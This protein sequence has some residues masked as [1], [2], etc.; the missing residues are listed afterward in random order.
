MSKKIINILS[1]DGGGSKGL[2]PAYLIKALSKE[3]DNN[4]LYNQFDLIA[5]TSTGALITLLLTSPQIA[6]NSNVDRTSLI[7]DLYKNESKKIF[8]NKFMLFK[9]LKQL[10]KPKFSNKYLSKLLEEYLGTT[11]IKNA[12]TNIIIP[13]FDMNTMQPY[14]F[15]NRP[16]YNGSCS[17]LNFYMK[18]VALASTAAPTYLPPHYTKTVDDFYSFNF[19]DGGLFANNPSM[20]AYIEAIKLFPNAKEFNIISLGT[21]YVRRSYTYK[22]VK[23][24]GALGWMNP[25]NNVPII[26]SYMYSQ[27]GSTSHKVSQISN[28]N[29][30]RFNPNISCAGLG[31]DSTTDEAIKT[32]QEISY[33]YISEYYFRI[34]QAANY[35]KKGNASK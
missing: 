6:N 31:M 1:I 3:L 12:L 13:T 24:W 4:P 25:F 22:K 14:F 9:T 10:V 26:N 35:I 17:D 23:K 27:E 34:K 7:I 11:T 16:C 19:V 20:S 2:I 30:F 15:K 33:M 21:G 5:G 32:M 18:D 28:V 8:N 29:Y